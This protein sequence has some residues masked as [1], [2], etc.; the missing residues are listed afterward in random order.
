LRDTSTFDALWSEANARIDADGGGFSPDAVVLLRQAM[1]IAEDDYARAA[2]VQGD[3]DDEERTDR[4]NAQNRL[5][6]ILHLLS[7]QLWLS[8][9]KDD[10]DEAI[11]LRIRAADLHSAMA[12]VLT[13]AQSHFSAYCDLKWIWRRL[14]K[15]AFRGQW[16]LFGDALGYFRRGVHHFWRMQRILRD[17]DW[18]FAD[19]RAANVG[20]T[21]VPVLFP[22]DVCDCELCA[23]DDDEG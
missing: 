10:Q 18:P 1:V 23:D 4:L 15:R 2:D 13:H 19:I 16:R 9:S 22:V 8:D 21:P 3:E 7:W 12:E 5:A 14:F 17:H 11:T 20:K 6:R